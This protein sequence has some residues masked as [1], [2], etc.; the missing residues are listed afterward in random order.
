M[1]DRLS[2]PLNPGD[3]DALAALLLDAVIDNAS[4]GFPAGLAAAEAAAFWADVGRTVGAGRAILLAARSEGRLVGTVQVRH[5]SYPNGRH[6]GELAKLLV[7]TSARRR[8]LGAALMAEA[9]REAAA[10]GLTLLYLDTESGSAA[11]GFYERLGWT[12]AGVIP[13]FAYRPDGE[14]RPSTFFYKR[15]SF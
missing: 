3:V 12:R 10:A 14:L 1:I 15:L 13:D 4:V 11:E 5:S 8:G 9:E 6:R 7:H 2:A